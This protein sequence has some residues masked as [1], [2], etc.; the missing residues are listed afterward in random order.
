MTDI[1][2]E[3]RNHQRRHG[4]VKLL[5]RAEAESMTGFISCYGFPK[6]T[7]DL[8]KDQ[9]GTFEL[10]EMPLYVDR[11][12]LDFDD[13]DDDY[14][15]SVQYCIKQGWSF[16]AYET[17]NRG[18]HI[19]IPVRPCT[20]VGVHLRVHNW[21]RSH[22]K[23]YDISLYKSSSVTRI[24]GTY[25]S[26]TGRKMVQ[27]A[28]ML[29]DPSVELPDIRDV[30]LPM[31][32]TAHLKEPVPHEDRETIFSLMLDKHVSRGG[33]RNYAFKLVT[34]GLDAGVSPVDLQRLVEDWSIHKAHPM[35]SSVE[36]SRIITSAQKRRRG[37]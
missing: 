35:I 8:I 6:V 10:A 30:A 18:Y 12:V 4:A 9:G 20:E 25:H 24:P 15:A 22:F 17:G 5:T 23:G 2:Y 31:P 13:H 32:I 1:L 11:V 33:R 21:V 34:C 36:V 3:L 14:Q 29:E 28:C 37:A 7:A 16:V 27:V 26:K 19:H